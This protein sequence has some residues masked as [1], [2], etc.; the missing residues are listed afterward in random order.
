MQ[1]TDILD[2]GSKK[3]PVFS[4]GFSTSE[5][6]FEYL[7]TNPFIIYGAGEAAHWFYEAGIKRKGL[8]PLAIVDQ[9]A[10]EIKN[11]EGIQCITLEKAI[12]DFEK[13]EIDIVVCIGDFESF[14]T[15][16][17]NLL[18]HGFQKVHYL[19]WFYEIHNLLEV[20]FLGESTWRRMFENNSKKIISTYAHFG[21]ELS[22]S[23]FADLINAHYY[24]QSK[25]VFQ[26]SS[27]RATF[28]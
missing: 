28:P 3:D 9:R 20:E 15:I 2:L 22:K 7:E 4:D 1:L 14:L 16:R 8:T 25:K 23:L 6:T 26:T 19:G 10:S 17:A 13:V 5:S 21:D 27:G 24:R 12:K 18:K 11:Y